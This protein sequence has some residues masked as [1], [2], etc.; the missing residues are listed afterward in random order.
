MLIRYY[1]DPLYGPRTNGEGLLLVIHALLLTLEIDIKFNEANMV[2][3]Y[4]YTFTI[5]RLETFRR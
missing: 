2:H 5:R 1:K 4:S 3:G